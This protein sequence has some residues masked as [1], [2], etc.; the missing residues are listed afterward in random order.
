MFEDVSFETLALD[1]P[2]DKSH[3]A[4][5]LL[6]EEMHSVRARSR[7]VHPGGYLT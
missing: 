7:E 3:G 6:V 4:G 5:H 1:I 2:I